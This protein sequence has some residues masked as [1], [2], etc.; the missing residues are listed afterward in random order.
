MRVFVQVINTSNGISQNGMIEESVQKGFEVA[1]A[2][3]HFGVNIN[4]VEWIYEYS[5]NNFKTKIGEVRD[6][7]KIVNV[8]ALIE[9][10]SD[11]PSD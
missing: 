6:T 5:K 1:N 9:V 2:L 10:V 11:Q 3:E 8:T 7:T 4:T